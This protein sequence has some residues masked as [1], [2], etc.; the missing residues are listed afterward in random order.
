[1]SAC[2]FAC[3]RVHPCLAARVQVKGSDPLTVVACYFNF[4]NCTFLLSAQCISSIGQ[5]IKSVA[6]VCMSVSHLKRV[7]RSTGRNLP[8]IFTKLATKVESQEM[9]LPIVLVEI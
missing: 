3:L 5:I 8:P 9:W 1:M 4:T 7:E 2:V 6:S